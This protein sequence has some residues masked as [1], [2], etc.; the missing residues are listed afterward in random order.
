LFPT[1]KEKL[2]RIQLADEDQF[3]ECVQGVLRGLDQQELKI[4]FQALV[5]R[6]QKV[7]EGKALETMSDDKQ[8]LHIRVLRILIRRAGACTFIPDD[9]LH[10]SVLSLHKTKEL[11]FTRL[12]QSP[13]SPDLAPCDFFLF[14]YL[15]TAELQGINFRSQNWVISAVTAILNEIPVRTLSRVFD[16]GSRDYTGAI[17]IMESLSQQ[18]SMR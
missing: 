11:G 2:E 12:S 1:V 10:N 14:G 3:F 8:F 18:L 4:V 6:V 7:S 9:K 5:H 13:Y 16:H 17:Q 15:K